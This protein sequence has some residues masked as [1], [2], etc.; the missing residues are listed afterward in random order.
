MSEFI[1]V[2]CVD[3]DIK[4]IIP[5]RLIE[6]IKDVE[7]FRFIACKRSIFG[8]PLGA[9]VKETLDE[10]MEMLESKAI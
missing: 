5:K 2:T 3:T 8:T 1:K 10:L 4:M 6:Y 7:D 9:S